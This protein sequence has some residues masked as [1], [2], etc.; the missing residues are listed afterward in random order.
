MS[1]YEF[2]IF[3]EIPSISMFS[4]KKK[5]KWSTT[6]IVT[7]QSI[8]KLL[9]FF[10]HKTC[11]VCD[12]EFSSSSGYILPPSYNSREGIPPVPYYCEYM[13]DMTEYQ[14]G[15]SDYT[16]LFSKTDS[17]LVLRMEGVAIGQKM[18]S[19]CEFGK[20]RI[21]VSSRECLEFKILDHLPL[22]PHTPVKNPGLKS[23]RQKIPFN[24]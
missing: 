6:N 20:S 7:L 2:S 14:A 5:Q 15:P 19:S 12:G 24:S 4:Q 18:G 21:S 23:P 13:H 10:F 3:D 17:T 9:N 22:G 8:K 1:T 11:T 16:A